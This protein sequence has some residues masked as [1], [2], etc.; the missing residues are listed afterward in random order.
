MLFH[1]NETICKA[2]TEHMP[3]HAYLPF[4][5]RYNS[6]S[7]LYST[8][9]P[10]KTLLPCPLFNTPP[11]LKR[12]WFSAQMVCWQPDPQRVS[13]GRQHCDRVAHQRPQP[14][15]DGGRCHVHN[16]QCRCVCVKIVDGGRCHVHNG[17]NGTH[18]HSLW[19]KIT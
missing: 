8:I 1:S 12:P 19:L 15:V 7:P 14:C 10:I 16:G 6:F 13:T 18:A 11:S 4:T 3:Q 2:K 17:H 9:L 5:N